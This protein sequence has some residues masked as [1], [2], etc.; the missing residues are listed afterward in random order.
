MIRDSSVA[1]DDLRMTARWRVSNFFSFA[2]FRYRRL[3]VLFLALVSL[4]PIAVIYAA[5]PPNDSAKRSEATSKEPEPGVF[6]DPMTAR[7]DRLAGIW[8]IVETQFDPK[9]EIISSVKGR[10]EVVWTL[11]NR[12]LRRTYT[13]K[14]EQRF[15][16]AIG[17]TTWN[18]P[19][20]K[21]RAAWFDNLGSS[22]P[23]LAVGAWGDE[24]DTLVWTLEARGPDGGKTEYRIIERLID[25][26][27]RIAT[28]YFVSGSDLV[29]RMDVHYKRALPCPTRG[30]RAID[31][32][33]SPAK[34]GDR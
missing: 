26:E 11:D 10:E 34:K 3:K 27:T 30:F 23:S 32:L 33:S 17:M 20:G 22:G 14:T 24:P 7:L 6:P 8:E 9:G 18:Q 25:E 4:L 29:K 21:Y 31:E 19:D 1:D 2:A 12:V 28:T 15:Y 16:W 13:T 5:D